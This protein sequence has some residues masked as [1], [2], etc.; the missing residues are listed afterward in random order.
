MQ[1][2]IKQLTYFAR[3]CEAGS[4]TR[5]ARE[6]N[7]A[8]TAL[9]L[10]VRSLE[11]EFGIT[12]FVRSPKGVAPTEGGRLLYQRSSAVLSAVDDLATEM[13]TLSEQSERHISLGLAP[14]VMSAI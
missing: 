9:G 7:V 8:Q 2:T 6:L 11:D 13:K 12:L 3:V 14:S 4:I 5:A 1:I 10:Q